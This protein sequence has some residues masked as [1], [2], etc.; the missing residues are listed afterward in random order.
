MKNSVQCTKCMQLVILS[1]YR[2]LR[3]NLKC[4]VD[5]FKSRMYVEHLLSDN[6]RYQLL[7]VHFIVDLSENSAQSVFWWGCFSEVLICT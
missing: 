2:E 1:E 5:G 6:Y 4:F 7:P 3:I